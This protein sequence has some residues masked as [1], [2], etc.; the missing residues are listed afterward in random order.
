MLIIRRWRRYFSIRYFPAPYRPIPY[1]PAPYHPALFRLPALLL[2]AAL[3]A[4]LLAAGGCATVTQPHRGPP[5]WQVQ[6]DG[7]MLWLFGTIHRLPDYTRVERIAARRRRAAT[8][9]RRIP[10]MPW[11]TIAVR[12]AMRSSQRLVVELVPVADQD[13]AALLQQ[14]RGQQQ[15]KRQPL[16]Q[17]AGKPLLDYLGPQEH[18]TVLDAAARRGIDENDLRDADPLLVF[19]LF[20]NTQP[21]TY[22]VFEPGAD[23]WLLF[24][25]TQR[26]MPVTGLETLSDRITALQNA[27]ARLR[28]AEQ[29]QVF[30]RYLQTELGEVAVSDPEYQELI[31][32][33]LNGD[34]ATLAHRMQ[35]YAEYL[36]AIHQAFIVERNRQWLQR[37][38]AMT[39]NDEDEFVAVGVG[40]LVGPDNLVEL[41]QRAGYSVT[42]VQ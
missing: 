10:P 2:L 13:V 38:S 5:L 22:G 29:A 19:S 25:A 14:Q 16:Q 6:H 18:Q 32:L 39:G 27:I 11:R 28:G 8:L 41:L 4:A 36:P 12:Q 24:E 33:W 30:L 31:R 26:E 23:F 20:A 42:R 15:R 37:I 35:R 34:T 9:I 3:S 17:A 7:D 21:A 40:H 1:R